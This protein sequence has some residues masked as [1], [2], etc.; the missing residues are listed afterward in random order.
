[1]TQKE[2]IEYLIEKKIFVDYI[3]F[4]I[5]KEFILEEDETDLI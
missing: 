3:L 4:P 1:M 2:V 5:E